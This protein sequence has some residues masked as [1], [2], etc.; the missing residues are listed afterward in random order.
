MK[1][2]ATLLFLA[3]SGLA[4]SQQVELLPPIGQGAGRDPGVVT[5]PDRNGAEVNG[6]QVRIKDI[7]RF[8]GMTENQLSGVGLVVGLE[9]TGDTQQTP[10]TRDLIANALRQWGTNVDP[11]ALRTRNIAAVWI[12]AEM[13][14]FVS[15]GS[16]IDIT[17]SSLGD[18]KSLQ[19]GQLL[20]TPLYGPTDPD[21]VIATA[22]GAV[23][24]GGFN[25]GRGTS[26][27]QRNHST[28]GRVPNGAIVQR[29]VPTQ[30]TFEGE[31]FLELDQPDLTNAQRIAEQLRLAFPDMA[32]QALDGGTIRI[33]PPLGMEPMRVLSE[34]EH[35]TVVADVPA[36]VII[37]ERTG[38]IVIGGNV[39][40]G[41]AVIA[42]GGLN[43]R[44]DEFLFVDQPTPF[45]QGQTV[46]GSETVTQVSEDRTQIAVVRPN[47]TIEDI[48]RMLHALQVGPRD[49]IAIFQM[50]ERQG[51]LR[52]RLRIE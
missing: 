6:V 50:L 40:I 47:A 9:G 27:Q 13:P 20:L 51:A 38:T 11:T 2:S 35:V 5:T 19:G 22:M 39:R 3:G 49:I 48:A 10:Y 34:I 12:T 42:H 14:A 45:S 33:R 44:I 28:A 16:R 18:A 36:V 8:R 15:P 30:L 37:N 21:T 1:L 26:T 4:L 29:S 24:I 23:S 31:M 43:V 52:A 32:A 25:V 41:P 7:A 17:V 46:V